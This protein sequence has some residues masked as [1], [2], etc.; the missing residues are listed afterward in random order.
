[1]G[2]RDSANLVQSYFK[3]DEDG[4][5]TGG[6]TDML[7]GDPDGPVR[8][9]IFIAYQ[10]GIVGEGGQTGAFVE[11]VI[12]AATQRI[13]F[14]QDSKFRCIENNQALYHLRK[15]LNALDKRTAKRSKAGIENTY[16]VS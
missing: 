1:M 14:F 16:E 11:D 2:Q 9:V 13:E 8:Q 3:T 10:D 12:Y 7:L 4:N 6:S 15:A 5:P